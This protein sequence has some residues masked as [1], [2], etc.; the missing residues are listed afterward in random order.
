MNM[1]CE[2]AGQ[3]VG[4][5]SPLFVIAELGLNHGGSVERALAMVD[6]AADAGASAVKLQSFRA[7]TLVAADCPPPAHVAAGSLRDFFR[8]FELDRDAHIQVRDRARARG[9]AFLSTPFSL[10]AV[11]MLDG[12]DVDALKIASGDLT[13]DP[14]IA[15]A[16]AT[17]RPLIISTGLSS[18]IETSQAVA[19]AYLHGAH[20]VALLHCVSCYPTPPDSQNL[21]VIETLGRLFDMPVGLSDHAATT[22]AVIPAVTLGAAIYER[23]LMLPGDDSVDAPVSSSPDEF[24][25]L[26][27]AAEQT[28]RALGHGRRECLA[29]EAVNLTAS[30]RSLYAT[31]RLMPGDVIAA[32]DLVALRPARGVPPACTDELI[33]APVA[34]V[35]E[36]GAPFLG[37]DV[38]TR[39]YREVA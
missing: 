25:A 8:T 5:S 13:F 16:A 32:G 27:A 6:A 38:V 3:P 26:V 31:R 39:R 19:T 1:H 35:I 18:T 34:R 30:R 17:G 33:G 28:R 37:C 12:L 14:L 22:A 23:H 7:D 24:K 10:E 36:A 4:G 9:L 21:R 29:A 2:I 20:H 11:D 15:R